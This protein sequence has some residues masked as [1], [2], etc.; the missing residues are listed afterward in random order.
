MSITQESDMKLTAGIVAILLTF[1]ISLRV[2]ADDG[3]VFAT[4]EN[5]YI[6]NL[7]T[8]QQYLLGT[9]ERIGHE[10]YVQFTFTLQPPYEY[11]LY[12]VVFKSRNA[13]GESS[14]LNSDEIE[15]E[16]T[17]YEGKGP[18]TVEVSFA[19]HHIPVCNPD[20]PSFI[21]CPPFI[22]SSPDAPPVPGCGC[23]RIN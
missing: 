6:E 10:P 9:V 14:G 13:T 22:I 8:A 18:H 12:R 1:P 4:G 3:S 17:V 21:G 11:G 5:F 2:Q 15:G 23:R 19:G 20:D 16:L 7:D